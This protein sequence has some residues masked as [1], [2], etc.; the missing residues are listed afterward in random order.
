MKTIALVSCVKKKRIV[1]SRAADLYV[2]TL[3]RLSYEYAK[4][5]KADQIWILSAKY[6]LLH[7]DTE[8]YP[9]ELTLNSMTAAQIA[10]WGVGVLSQLRQ[11]ADLKRD[12]FLI[13][14]GEKYRRELVGAIEHYEVPMEGLRLG[15]QMAWLKRQIAV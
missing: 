6:G 7:P 12:H 9:Y 10:K 14:A 13:L 3:F 8:V 11:V 4:K 1:R 5:L 15:L 2:S